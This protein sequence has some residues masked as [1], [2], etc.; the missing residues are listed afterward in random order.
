MIIVVIVLIIVVIVLFAHLFFIKNEL[1]KLT[2]NLKSINNG[3]S[4]NN[5][6]I[7]FFN[8]EI[9][10]LTE[11]INKNL[12]EKKQFEVDKIRFQNNFRKA[13]SDISHD[14][15]TPLTS[16]KG[17]IQFLKLGNLNESEKSEYIN[18][19]EERVKTLEI[20]LNDFYELSLIDSVEYELKFDKVNLSRVVQEALLSKY[21][22]FSV[23]KVEPKIC[24]EDKNI[25]IIGDNCALGR[26]VDN[27]LSNAIKYFKSYIK[28]SLTREN[29][30]VI[31]KV[32]NDTE[33]LETADEERIFDRFYMADKTRSGKG[34]GLGLSIAKELALKM[35]GSINAELKD[36]ALIICCKFKIFDI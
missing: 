23:K 11:E 12:E 4:I 2:R 6:T 10:S 1:K 15:R 31:F 29:D 8:K 30:C 35:K 32:I 17:Y 9:E 13:T 16:I 22:E 36:N 26:I 18:I 34:T 3:K 21:A 24:I 28:I 19:I 27:L 5:L 33:N 20:L 7:S 25:F 14:L